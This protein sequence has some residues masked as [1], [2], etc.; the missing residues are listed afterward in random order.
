[1]PTIHFTGRIVPIAGI[2]ISAIDLPTPKYKSPEN[3]LEVKFTFHINSSAVD[4]ECE[5][6]RFS[7]DPDFLK[8]VYKPAFDLTQA[9]V[10]LIGFQTGYGLMVFFEYI[11]GPDGVRHY[12]CVKNNELPKLCTAFSVASGFPEV[13]RIVLTDTSLFIALNELNESLTLTH[14]AIPSCA[15][16][17]ERLRTN[18]C[19]G[20]ERKKAW[21]QFGDNL[22]ISKTYLDLITDYSKGPRHGDP[23][24][25]PENIVA[26][27][28]RRSWIIVNRFLEYRKRGSSKLPA[29]EFPLL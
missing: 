19:P 22:Q 29:S 16:C 6:S 1:M 21:V 7:E 24:Y 26:E 15:R 3:N 12:F 27:V 18:M 25:I 2:N 23:E 13:L 9:I 5:L 8:T 14:H 4:V 11:I 28:M 10:S 20:L 17:I